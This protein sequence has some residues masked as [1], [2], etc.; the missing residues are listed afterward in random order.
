[1]N[2]ICLCLLNIVF[3]DFGHLISESFD[4]NVIMDNKIRN[5]GAVPQSTSKYCN[6][7]NCMHHD[8]ECQSRANYNCTKNEAIFDCNCRHRRHRS[9]M[10]VFVWKTM[11]ILYIQRTLLHTFTYFV[12][13]LF[14]LF[15]CFFLFSYISYSFHVLEAIPICQQRTVAVACLLGYCAIV[16]PQNAYRHTYWN[17]TTNIILTANQLTT[18]IYSASRQELGSLS[19]LPKR[20][21]CT[22]ERCTKQMGEVRY[23]FGYTFSAHKDTEIV[24]TDSTIFTFHKYCNAKKNYGGNTQTDTHDEHNMAHGTG[25]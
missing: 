13:F 24:L 11:Y 19:I 1:M 21:Y 22:C 2:C 23:R 16:L 12:S 10:G 15:N 25:N 8:Y 14:F 3:E 5:C 18:H 4:I 17:V 9:A 6:F 20:T 7:T